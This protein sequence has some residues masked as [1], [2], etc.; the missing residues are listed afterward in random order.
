[1]S[2]HPYSFLPTCHEGVSPR[3]QSTFSCCVHHHSTNFAVHH[4][5]PIRLFLSHLFRQ[6][7]YQGSSQPS[8]PLYITHSTTLLYIMSPPL[9]F[10]FPHPV[11]QVSLPRI[12]PFSCCSTLHSVPL[13]LYTSCHTQL[14]FSSLP[15]MKV[16]SPRIQSTFQLLY[17]NSQYHFAVHIMSHQ[18][19]FFFP[20]PTCRCSHQGS[21]FN[22]SEAVVHHFHVPLCCKASCHTN[23]TLLPTCHVGVSH[24][25]SMSTFSCCTSP[26]QYH[27]YIMSHHLTLS[28]HF[29]HGVP[30]YKDPVNLQLLYIIS[31]VPIDSRFS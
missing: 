26:S 20:L 9:F 24:Q 17:I 29:R 16:S 1:M 2:H 12:Q 10:L 15:V 19:H 11:R 28:S 27:L 25:G 22:L 14:H 31:Q 23:L 21:S 13:L 4:V 3:I 7:L 5:T 8:Q 6:C 18:S 30:H